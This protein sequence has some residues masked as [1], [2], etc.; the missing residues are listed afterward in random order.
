MIRERLAD[1]VHPG[2]VGYLDGDAPNTEQECAR[3]ARL[4]ASAPIDL[5]MVGFG[6]N[7]HIAFNDPAVA[8]FRDPLFVK[9]VCLDERCRMQQV[10]EGHF[11]NLESVPAEALTITCPAIMRSRHLVCCVPDRRKAESVL[12]ALEGPVSEDCPASIVRTHPQAHIFLRSGVCL[13]VTALRRGDGECRRGG[14]VPAARHKQL[15]RSFRISTQI[16]FV[17]SCCLSGYGMA[18][19]ENSEASLIF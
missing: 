4:L 1:R 14:L 7:G 6:E 16:I 19:T 11:P 10:G 3:Y 9:R 15:F 13:F 17:P 12:L 2:F 5:C 8:D 18:L